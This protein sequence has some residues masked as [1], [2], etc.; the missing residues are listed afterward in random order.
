MEEY[1]F[2]LKN[3]EEERERQRLKARPVW[4]KVID[5]LPGKQFR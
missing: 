3:E 1:Q 5:I 4:Q 2:S